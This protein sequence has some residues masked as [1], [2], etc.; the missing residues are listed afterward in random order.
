[1]VEGSNFPVRPPVGDEPTDAGNDDQQPINQQ[2]INQGGENPDEHNNNKNNTEVC[3]H[4]GT[5]VQN[6]IENNRAPNMTGSE[7]G[8]EIGQNEKPENVIDPVPQVDNLQSINNLSQHNNPDTDPIL[9][10]DSQIEDEESTQKPQKQD[11]TILPE[12]VVSFPNTDTCS[13]ITNPSSES[14]EANIEVADIGVLQ[15]LVKNEVKSEEVVD[16]NAISPTKRIIGTETANRPEAELIL[17]DDRVNKDQATPLEKASPEILASIPLETHE[18][19]V[20]AFEDKEAKIDKVLW[21]VPGY[22]QYYM[23]DLTSDLSELDSFEINISS[24]L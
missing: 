10:D 15:S 12:Q 1:M 13:T 4:S 23:K 17:E 9:S 24:P 14:D 8:N 11:E 21:V 2:L 22:M 19:M 3:R 5:I 6:N 18:Y 16:L 20:T 7:E